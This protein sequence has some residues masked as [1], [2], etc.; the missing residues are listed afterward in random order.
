MAPGPWHSPAPGLLSWPSLKSSSHRPRLPACPQPDQLCRSTFRMKRPLVHSLRILKALGPRG[1]N[2]NPR[3]SSCLENP[4]D[5]RV[6][7]S[8]RQLSDWPQSTQ[9]PLFP[10]SSA[11]L[12]DFHILFPNTKD[13]CLST[14]QWRR[15]SLERLY[16][17]PRDN[18]FTDQGLQKR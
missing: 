3:Q 8:R 9:E 16:L 14:S 2:G 6:T 7:K 13:N 12:D 1:G 15:E 18:I 10:S 11:G 17:S 5:R 4:M